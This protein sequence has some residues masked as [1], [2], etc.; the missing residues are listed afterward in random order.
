M[1][2]YGSATVKSLSDSILNDQRSLEAEA[3]C[4]IETQARPPGSDRN[5][6]GSQ[7]GGQV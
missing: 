3:A 5:Q 2:W 1:Q 7:P 4:Q 6:T